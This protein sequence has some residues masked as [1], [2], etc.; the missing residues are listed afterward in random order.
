MGLGLRGGA[1][2]SPTLSL[3][4]DDPA[5]ER[6]EQDESSPHSASHEHSHSTIRNPVTAHSDAQPHARGGLQGSSTPPHPLPALFSASNPLVQGEREEEGRGQGPAVPASG[7]GCLPAGV[8][9]AAAGSPFPH[10]PEDR[11]LPIGGN[12]ATL[13]PG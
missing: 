5:L 9:T 4:S 11:V 13:P 7:L 6:V 2:L 10:P 3:G 12:G 1:L 8:G